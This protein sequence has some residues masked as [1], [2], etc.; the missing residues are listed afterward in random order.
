MADRAHEKHETKILLEKDLKHFVNPDGDGKD[1]G[2]SKAK[3][4]PTPEPKANILSKVTF[5]WLNSLLLLGY[6]RP[7]AEGDLYDVPH[8]QT[9]D[10]ITNRFAKEWQKELDIHRA[11][12]KAAV[13][14]G[15]K[16]S[17]PAPIQ[18]GR[19]TPSLRRALIRTFGI[20]WV[21]G[22]LYRLVSDTSNVTQPLVLQ[23]FV[24]WLTKSGSSDGTGKTGYLLALAMFAL[25][26]LTSIFQHQYFY[27]S[28]RVGFGLRTAVVASVYRKCLILSQAARQDF[29]GGRTVNMMSTDTARLDFVSPQLHMMWAS[30]TIICVCMG[31]LIMNLGV[32]ALAGFFVLLVPLLLQSVVIRHLMGIRKIASAITDQRIRV[33][34]EALSGIRVIKFNGWE[35]AILGMIEELRRTELVNVRKIVASRSFMTGV[36][37]IQP[38]FAAILTFVIYTALGNQLT[39][40]V[41]FSSLALF[42]V[43]RMPL[44]MYPL[45]IT[46]VS[47]AI[48][49]LKRLETLLLADELQADDDDGNSEHQEQRAETDIKSEWVVKIT[50][51]NFKWEEAVSVAKDTKGAKKTPH[52]AKEPSHA[53]LAPVPV[54]IK[55]AAVA[56]DAPASV[57]ET[58]VKTKSRALLR[59]INV[60]IPKGSLVFVCGAV[61]SGKS[62]LLNAIIGEMGKT[63]GTVE[64][65]AASLAYG[66]QQ[67]WVQNATVRENIVFGHPWNESKYWDAIRACSMVSDLEVLADG[68][69][70]EIGERGITLSG[71]QKQRVS[72]A[73]CVFMDP[74]LVILDDPLSAVDAHV[75]KHIL[76]EVILKRFSGKTRIMATHQLHILPHSDFVICLNEGEIV[77]QG[78]YAELVAKDGG[79][80][81]EMVKNYGTKNKDEVDEKEDEEPSSTPAVPEFKTTKKRAGTKGNDGTLMTKEERNEGAVPIVNYTIYAKAS[82]GILTVGGLVLSL[83]L[84]QV[85]RVGT[86]TWLSFWSTATDRGNEGYYM[87]IYVVL[88]LLQGIFAIVNGQIIAYGCNI[89]SRRIHDAALEKVFRAPV[90]F[91]D[92]TPIGRIMNRFSRDID[93][94]DNMLPENLR[95]F[96]GQVSVAISTLVLVCVI[97]P[98]FIAPIVPMI[99]LYYFIQLFYRSTSRELKRL[100]SILRSPFYAHFSETLAGLSTIRAFQAQ[101]RFR[102]ENETRLNSANRS[103]W[104][105]AVVQRWIAVRLDVISATLV[106][107]ATVFATVLRNSYLGVGVLS[108]AVTYS[109][110]M[111]NVL[112]FTVR[113]ATELEMQMNGVERLSYYVNDLESEKAPVVEDRR[114]PEGW[115]N[116]GEITFRDITLRYR[117]EL[118]PALEDV[119]LHFKPGTRVGICGRTGAGKST[120]LMS[121][122]R[123]VEP[124][125]GS[126]D[127]DGVNV[128]EIG[129]QD[130]R[131]RLAII[132]QDPVLFSGTF[133]YNLDPF[134]K[135]P[136][137]EI[138]SVLAHCGDL[139]DVV[140]AHPDKLEM[141]VSENGENF[142]VGQRQLICLARA[143]LRRSRVVV[144]DEA[145]ASVDLATDAFIQKS[146]RSS[147]VFEQS[148]IVTIA[149]RIQTIIDYDMIVVMS[150]GKVVEVGTPAELV[151]VEGGWFAKL[152]LETGGAQAE[153]LHRLAK[154]GRNATS[155]GER[156][157]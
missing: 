94:L 2:E 89:A 56:T 136:D 148:T 87:G 108:L 117:P 102:L 122:F 127:I 54:P 16:T 43:V 74:E 7:L 156:T 23:A 33:I 140:E 121:L 151:D 51:G 21:L 40:G 107:C 88:G 8:Y 77:E 139:R 116:A 153:N 109:L 98:L 58:N 70:T 157:C 48:V 125:S 59:N 110:S 135:Y 112:S 3:P 129:L 24:N 105:L 78:T 124:T 38:V 44:Q 147:D 14:S 75:G 64:I 113:Q 28:V 130:L 99:I 82:G 67:A 41:V 103:T 96:T 101:E 20:D 91:F 57:D 119:N 120:L 73:R 90:T 53:K 61:G 42:N 69:L 144:L 118:P 72:L 97:I 115:P 111:T 128:L 76:E 133:R 80:L 100:D 106:F 12:K 93:G 62:S 30:P 126:I 71:G 36:M 60:A 123:L 84:T 45:Q 50:N 37:Q 32:S 150:Q 17:A 4:N 65:N 22:G 142:S 114:P 152:V 79:Y 11:S 145:T 95:M 92:V 49:A 47:D 9:V 143:A 55:D 34:Q 132:P 149:H 134:E 137:N 155:V 15:E 146:L 86:D 138:W 1:A 10:A 29:S 26:I 25:Q 19:K 141:L 27:N 131:D 52:G 31:L 81:S 104:L 46:M 154:L 6:R 5:H 35:D 83:V 39:P 18:K 63:S 85:A 68:D 13:A 66:A